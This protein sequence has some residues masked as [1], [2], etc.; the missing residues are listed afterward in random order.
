MNIHAVLW[1]YLLGNCLLTK[2]REPTCIQATHAEHLPLF[3]CWC[4]TRSCHCQV[5]GRNRP[6]SLPSGT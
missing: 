1:G 2:W 6:H 4:R 3:V 5:V